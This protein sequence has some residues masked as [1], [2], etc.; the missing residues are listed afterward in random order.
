MKV[1]FLIDMDGVIYSGPKVIPGALEFI[2]G[3]LAREVPFCF[4]TNNSRF[5]QR[6]L[7]IRLHRMGFKGIEERHLFTS[8][9]ATGAFLAKQKRNATAYVLGEGGLVLSLHENG[10]AVVDHKPDYVIVGEGRNFTLEM[11]EKAIDFIIDGAKLVATNLDP[12]PR[13]KGWMKPGIAAIVA[14]LENATGKKAFSVGKPSPV[15][16]RAARK[17]LGLQSEETCVI[18]DTMQTDILGGVQLGYKT[19]LVLSGWSN[20]DTLRDFSYKPDLIAD[21]LAS[22]DLDVLYEHGVCEE[23]LFTETH[24]RPAVAPAPSAAEEVEDLPNA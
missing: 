12:S 11:F 4:M 8:A 19:I 9:M 15:M 21:S 17:S 3:L 16:L 7:A 23:A 20:R 13:I 22:L 14:L 18:G 10:L 1:G 6:D 24:A 2:N 5:T